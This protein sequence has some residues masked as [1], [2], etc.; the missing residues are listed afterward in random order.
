[1]RKFFDRDLARAFALAAYAILVS[2]AV[3]FLVGELVRY[4]MGFL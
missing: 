4:V 2:V 3:S 1:M